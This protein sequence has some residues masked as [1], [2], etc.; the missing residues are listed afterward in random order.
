MTYGIKVYN[1]SGILQ[2]TDDYSNHVLVQ[3]GTIAVGARATATIYYADT[4]T[5]PLI[6]LRTSSGAQVAVISYTNTSCT[7]AADA[8]SGT[9]EYRIYRSA[10]GMGASSDTYGLRVWSGSSVLVFDTGYSYVR[11]GQVSTFNTNGLSAGI[12]NI[13]HAHGQAFVS[14]S[15]ATAVAGFVLDHYYGAPCLISHIGIQTSNNNVA[16]KVV[17]RPTGVPVTYPEQIWF[18]SLRTIGVVLV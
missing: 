15:M 5:L 1:A 18:N 4:G 11:I 9:V 2:I 16:I 7:L 3:S 17:Q 12:V 6:A 14:L 13:P 8:S 10:A